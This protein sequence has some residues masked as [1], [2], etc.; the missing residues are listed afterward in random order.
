[1]Y[2]QQLPEIFG[3]RRKECF[4]G[5]IRLIIGSGNVASNEYFISIHVSTTIFYHHKKVKSYR[6][7]K[8][9]HAIMISHL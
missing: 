2:E 4:D 7:M 8:L 6:T 9:D 5:M 1:M 3:P